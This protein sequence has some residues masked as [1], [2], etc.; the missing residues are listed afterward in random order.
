MMTL[1]GHTFQSLRVASSQFSQAASG[2]DVLTLTLSI[3]IVTE[4]VFV[5]YEPYDFVDGS[6]TQRF[7][8]DLAHLA[9]QPAQSQQLQFVSAFRF[10]DLA[11]ATQ[12]RPVKNPTTG[13]VTLVNMTALTLGQAITLASP[14]AVPAVE[15]ISASAQVSALKTQFTTQFPTIPFTGNVGGLELPWSLRTN[16]TIGTCLLDILGWFPTYQIRSTTTGLEIVNGAGGTAHAI[17]SASHSV[18]NINIRPRHDLLTSETKITFVKPPPSVITFTGNNGGV[19]LQDSRTDTATT[20]NGSP[21]KINLTVELEAGEPFPSDA[22]ASTFQAYIGQL[23][24]DVDLTLRGLHWN[25]RPGHRLNLGGSFAQDADPPIVQTISRDLF[26]RTCQIKAGPRKH[27]GLDKLI[28]LA[29]KRSKGGGGGDRSPGPLEE[30]GTLSVIISGHP[31]AGNALWTVGDNNGRGTAEVEL[32]PGDYT[33]IF[34]PYWDQAGGR[35][36]FAPSVNVTITDGDTST[37]TGEFLAMERLFLQNTSGTSGDDIDL[38]C[39]DIGSGLGVAKIRE[40]SWIAPDLTIY[41]AHVL[42]TSPQV[43]GEATLPEGPAGPEGPQGPAGT[44]GAP[45]ADGREPT[46]ATATCGD[47]TIDITFTYAD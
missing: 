44:N 43:D 25:I 11:N 12:L 20:E 27:L 4:S 16:A 32:P 37:A 21:R 18:K 46:G 15:K 6:F 39:V 35:L 34:P 13:E 30:A 7:W 1:G 26:K 29:R 41:K 24:L 42:C 33:V 47:G 17:S 10:L 23:L 8:L 31:D 2:E 3:P 14:T 19:T 45:G 36:Y 40:I 5:P 28:E 38:N 9:S 22:I